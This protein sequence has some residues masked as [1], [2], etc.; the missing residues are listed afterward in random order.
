MRVS[1]RLDHVAVA[2]TFH[3]VGRRYD[4]DINAT[5]VC[6]NVLDATEIGNILVPRD[7]NPGMM[8]IASP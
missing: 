6:A 7:Q 1:P 8:C 4:L 3:I 5:D 2:V